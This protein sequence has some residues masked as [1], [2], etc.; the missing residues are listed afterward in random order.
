M[1][2]FATTLSFCS[3][4]LNSKFTSFDAFNRTL[5][6]YCETPEQPYTCVWVVKPNGFY[7]GN[8]DSNGTKLNSW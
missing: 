3:F 5:A 6:C 4:Q 1:N 7:L 2:F 8:S